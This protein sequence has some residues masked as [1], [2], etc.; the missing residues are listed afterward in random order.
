MHCKRRID[1]RASGNPVFRQSAGQVPNYARARAIEQKGASMKPTDTDLH[2]LWRRYW[3]DSTVRY[4]AWEAGCDAAWQAWEANPIGRPP[5]DPP[6]PDDP[7]PDI[8]RGLTCGARTRAGTPCKRI[9]LY[10][11]GRCKLHGGLSTGPRSAEGKA[12]ASRNGKRTPLEG[13][14]G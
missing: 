13:E 5:R 7:F 6:A 14:K 10:R 9:D 1:V 11:S 12:V 2:R 3:R 4:T 8:L